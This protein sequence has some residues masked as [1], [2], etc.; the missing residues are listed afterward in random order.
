MQFLEHVRALDLPKHVAAYRDSG[1]E[2]RA[3][4]YEVVDGVAVIDVRGTFTKYAVAR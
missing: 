2:G 4:T 1:R 3:G